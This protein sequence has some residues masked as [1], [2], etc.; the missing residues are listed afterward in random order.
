[1]LKE[2]C[3]EV[4]VYLM[5]GGEEVY[6]LVVGGQVEQFINMKLCFKLLQLLFQ[7]FLIVYFDYKIVYI[8]EVSVFVCYCKYIVFCQYK[9]FK[10]SVWL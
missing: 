1:M 10:F 4:F 3:D 6:D 2:M 5:I 7:C 8:F 9:V